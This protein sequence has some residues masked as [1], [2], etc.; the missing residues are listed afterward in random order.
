MVIWMF[1]YI[2]H[3]KMSIEL[4]I[5][6]QS[7]QVRIYAQQVSSTT[8]EFVQIVRWNMSLQLSPPVVH[9]RR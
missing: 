9:P 3:E 6:G 2:I 1:Q 4:Y 5:K 7:P 8:K